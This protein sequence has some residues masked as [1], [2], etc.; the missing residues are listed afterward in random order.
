MTAVF[1]GNNTFK[2]CKTILSLQD[3][4][5]TF[6]VREDD[7]S[8]P[9]IELYADSTLEKIYNMISDGMLYR[10]YRMT[11]I[12]LFNQDFPILPPSVQA[13]RTKGGI[14]VYADLR[15][16]GINFYV[17]HTGAIQVNGAAVSESETVMSDICFK[18]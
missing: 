3:G 9:V 7:S 2:Y 13:V 17:D 11:G 12:V 1:I 6:G 16:L 14:L 15:P 4:K 5:F 8:E 10:R 18:L